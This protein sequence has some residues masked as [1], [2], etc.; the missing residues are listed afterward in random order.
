MSQTYVPT[1]FNLIAPLAEAI[2]EPTGFP[3]QNEYQWRTNL[4]KVLQQISGVQVVVSGGDATTAIQ[5]GINQVIIQGGGIVI[6]PA[7]NF[8]MGTVSVPAGS[9]PIWIRGEGPSTVVTRNVTLAPGIGMFDVSSSNFWMTDFVIDGGTTT[10]RGLRYNADFSTSINVN[11]PMAPSLTQN[12]SVWVHGAGSGYRFDRM[13]FQHAGGYSLLFDATT[14]EISDVD[15]LSCWFMNNRPTLFGAGASASIYG[16]WNG[17]LFF[18]GDGRSAAGSQSG[19]L[20]NVLV[21]GCRFERNTGNCAWSHNY[22]FN[23]FNSNFRFEGNQFTDCGLDGILVDVVSG[24]A[25]VGNTFRRIGY[26]TLTDVDKS[27]PRWLANLNATAIDSGVVKG[28]SYIGN[29]ITSANGGAIDLDTFCMGTVAG[30]TCR[31]PYIDEPEFTEDS[32]AISGSAGAGNTSYGINLGVTYAIAEGGSLINIEGNTLLNL[33]MGAMRLYSMR[34]GNVGG[35]LIDH[36]D[37]ATNPIV[38]GPQGAAAYN[39]CYGNRIHGNQI[40]WAPGSAI[41][42]ITED[43]TFAAFTGGEIDYVYSNAPILGGGS[44]I[45]FAKSA[46]SGSTVYSEQVWFP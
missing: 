3:T 33:P 29:S 11:D 2:T 25:V 37:T 19:V 17:C 14:G 27:I 10:P 1:A 21:Q 22:G 45:E 31:I 24:A 46:T 18:K 4:A 8:T 42:A 5:S 12:T 30:N 9:P 36:P 44:A 40:R 13:V 23:R 16:S 35:N 7:G 43:E 28:A 26:T 41:A 20:S 39:R 15:V 6:L 34:Y 32:I 38:L